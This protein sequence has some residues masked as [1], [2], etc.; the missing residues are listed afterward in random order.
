VV[1]SPDGKTLASCGTDRTVRLWHVATRRELFTLLQDRGHVK[2]IQFVS[3]RQ[4]LVGTVR[5]DTQV[6]EVRVF[7]AGE[8]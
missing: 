5:E 1:F 2:W 7:D 3:P 8:P 6:S 4:L